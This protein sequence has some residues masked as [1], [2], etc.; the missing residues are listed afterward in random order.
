MSSVRKTVLDQAVGMHRSQST[1]L[2]EP[3]PLAYEHGAI[4]RHEYVEVEECGE[5]QF[6]SLGST[7]T[8]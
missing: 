7:L 8:E 2:L 3:H 4:G 5:I 6:S 1:R